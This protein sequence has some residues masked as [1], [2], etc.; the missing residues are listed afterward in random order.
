MGNHW[1]VPLFGGLTLLGL[2]GM[3][4]AGVDVAAHI[5]GFIC[6][7]LLGFVGACLQR[8]LPRLNRWRMMVGGG[9]LVIIGVAWT[10]AFIVRG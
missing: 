5:S 1:L 7:I 9:A 6:G 4:E 2:F 3:G 8:M 10:W